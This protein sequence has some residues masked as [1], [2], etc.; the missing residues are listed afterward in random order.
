MTRVATQPSSSTS[1]SVIRGRAGYSTLSALRTKPGRPDSIPSAS[2]SCS[3][4][5]ASW[6][7]LGI[8]GGLLARLFAPIYLEG[9]VIGGVEEP[10]T[11]SH[12][13]FGGDSVA[14]VPRGKV[15]KDVVRKEVERAIWGRLEA[16]EREHT[17]CRLSGLAAF[18]L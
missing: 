8:Q 4:K 2:M 5:L 3:D 17:N 13:A 12:A 18:R 7:V 9:I 15:W 11:H 1:G 14:H 6:S 10:P 16:I